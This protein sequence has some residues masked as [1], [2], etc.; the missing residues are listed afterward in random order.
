M[1]Y[2]VTMLLLL[3]VV[4][5]MIVFSFKLLLFIACNCIS[6]PVFLVLAICSLVVVPII[7]TTLDSVYQQKEVS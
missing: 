1:F 7:L 5:V 4:V 3:V 2:I 6:L